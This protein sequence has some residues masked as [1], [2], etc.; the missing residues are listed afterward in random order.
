LI[1][2]TARTL[3]SLDGFLNALVATC[4]PFQESLLPLR[5]F[6]QPFFEPQIV[7]F[8][9]WRAGLP[10]SYSFAELCCAADD[11]FVPSIFLLRVTPVKAPN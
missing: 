2:N 5:H 6:P 3:G 10:L 4:A 8:R 11:L 7:V 1:F 9:L